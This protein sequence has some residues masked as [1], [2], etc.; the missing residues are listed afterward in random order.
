LVAIA[1]HL[2]LSI[3]E[4]HG[5]GC[6]LDDYIARNVDAIRRGHPLNDPDGLERF[7]AAHLQ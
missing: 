2:G 1:K 7:V 4:K 3:A 5:D 6:G